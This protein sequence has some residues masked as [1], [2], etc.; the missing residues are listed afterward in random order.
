MRIIA[1]HI[2]ASVMI[3]GDEKGIIPSNTGYGYV[4]R[5][6]IRRAVRYAKMI[7][8]NENFTSKLSD[9]VIKIYKKVYPEI[10]KNKDFIKR[11]LE[12]EENK[13]R[14]TLENGLK[15]LRKKFEISGTLKEIVEHPISGKWCFDLFQTYGFPKE[16]I[17]EELKNLEKVFKRCI[18][19]DWQ[20]TSDGFDTEMRKHQDLSRTASVGMFKGGLADASEETKNCTQLLI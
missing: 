10:E 3:L 1:D 20:R 9:S 15:E 7:D 5:R 17:F 8:I 14:K 2:K 19:L 18:I 12:A 4:L 13:F 16:M 11:E 6:L